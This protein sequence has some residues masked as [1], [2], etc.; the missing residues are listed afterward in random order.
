MDR[1]P[2]L[3]GQLKATFEDVAGIDLADA[4]PASHFIELGLDS[5]N[6]LGFRTEALLEKVFDRAFLLENI[7]LQAGEIGWRALQAFQRGNEL[8]IGKILGVVV[9]DLSVF[10]VLLRIE[11]VDF[12]Q[13]FHVGRPAPNRPPSGTGSNGVPR[14]E[15]RHWHP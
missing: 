9:E 13:G 10:L 8:G 5:Q 4:D 7:A 3:I 11:Q 12:A 14:A 1:Q 6:P 2:R 15:H